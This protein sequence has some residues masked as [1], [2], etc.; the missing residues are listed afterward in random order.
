LPW[1]SDAPQK[2]AGS[3]PLA[4]ADVKGRWLHGRRLFF[5]TAACATCHMIRGE[6]VVF[7]PDLSNLIFRDRASVLHDILQPS[8]TINPDHAGSLIKFT[9]GEGINGIVRVLSDENIIVRQAGGVET[10]RP[11]NQVASIEPMRNSLMPENYGQ[12]LSPEQQEDLLTFLLTN[13]LEPAHIT[14]LE[15]ATPPPRTRKEIAP[16]FSV[17]N[18]PP[19]TLSP[20]RLLLV[21]DEKDHGVDEH[22]YPLWVERWSKLLAL[23]DNVTVVTNKGFPSLEQLAGADVT[24]FF[25]RNTG[26]DLKTAALLDEYQARGGGL[27]YLHWAIEGG[28]DTAAL[29]ERIGLAF[30]MSKFRHGAMQLGFN[31]VESPI[32]RGFTD[33]NFVDETYWALH[34]D[35]S[36]VRTLAEVVEENTPRPQLWTTQRG[37][38]R[39]FVCI[40]GHFTWT[41][42]DPLYR[43]LVLRGIAW[44]AGEKDVNRLTELAVVGARIAP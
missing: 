19:E 21:A 7:G 35:V 33:L 11:R 38:G 28:K 25:S 13:P 15:P 41:F 4:R 17:S 8:A 31:K 23:A 24:I 30:S 20:L 40:P 27:V 12:A 1:A 9:D 32:T 29:A 39:V 22:D 6:G 3:A 34:G 14:R 2:A 44:A 16:F 5:G 37:K 18:T 42:D 43:I 10:E 26:W 36:H